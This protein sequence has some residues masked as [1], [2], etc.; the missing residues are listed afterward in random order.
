[1]TNGPAP[2]LEPRAPAGIDSDAKNDHFFKSTG[3]QNYLRANRNLDAPCLC[4]GV[5]SV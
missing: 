2:Q 3:I 5:G 4:C 1:L